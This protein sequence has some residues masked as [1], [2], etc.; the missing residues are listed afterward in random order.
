MKTFLKPVL[1]RDGAPRRA[2]LFS[3]SELKITFSGLG[4]DSLLVLSVLFPIRNKVL[5]EKFVVVPMAPK[6][7]EISDLS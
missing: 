7:F 2:S 5:I 3:S 4:R 1:L 6:T